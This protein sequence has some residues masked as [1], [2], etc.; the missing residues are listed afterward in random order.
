M[1]FVY[2][3]ACILMFLAF[4]AVLFTGKYPK[5][6]YGFQINVLSW[7]ARLGASMF[8]LIDGYPQIG[9]GGS[10]P[11]ITL[12]AP[13]PESLSRLTLILRLLFSFFYVVIPH[14]FCLYFRSLWGYVLLFLAWWVVLFT[15][16]YPDSFF[17]Y[18]AGT[19]RWGLRY[20][21][22]MLFLTDKYPPFT[23]K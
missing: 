16:K 2:I 8:N 5:S 15:G 18:Q 6:W 10:N 17:N 4:W 13:Y 14:G 20:G 22:Y 23:G 21:M 7:G 11:S 9:P 3:W 19:I 1:I 12:N